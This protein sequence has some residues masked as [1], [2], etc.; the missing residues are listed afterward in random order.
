MFTIIY[1]SCTPWYSVHLLVYTD[2][3]TDADCGEMCPVTGQ[4]P[5][6]CQQGS[7]HTCTVCD[8]QDPACA[9]LCAADPPR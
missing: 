3:A 7:G 5:E 4:E 1:N 6:A 2:G 9:D 8:K